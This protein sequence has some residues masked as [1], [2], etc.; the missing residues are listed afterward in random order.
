MSITLAIALAAQGMSAAAA[1]DYANDES[2]LCRPGRQDAC[3]ENQDVTVVAADGST[4]I[5]RFK[6]AKTPSYDCFYVYPTV[7][8]D[9][10]PNSDMAIGPEERR[11][12]H[13]QVARF[14]SQ[15]RVF[16]PMYRQVTL[17]ALRSAMMGQPLAADR[18]MTLSDVKAAWTITFRA[19]TRGAVSC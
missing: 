15:C 4:S 2:W 8:L 19:T 12:A 18:A 1:P 14:A 11:V 3:S 7:S 13:A 9:S 10:T 6:R 16:A 5:E 17:T